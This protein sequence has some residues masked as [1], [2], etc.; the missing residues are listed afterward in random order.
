MTT[1]QF[2]SIGLDIDELMG[3]AAIEWLQD[4]TTIDTSDITMLSASAKLFIRK[5]AEINGL[6]SGVSSESIEGM[7]QSYNQSKKEDMIWDLA[8]S[9]LSGN[10]KSRVRFV[11]AQRKWQGFGGYGR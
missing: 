2:K 1:E 4:N 6:N 10:L 3:N 5:F 9:L 11:T 8:N 7:S